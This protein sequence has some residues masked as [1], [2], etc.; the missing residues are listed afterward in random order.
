[1]LL[2]HSVDYSHKVIEYHIQTGRHTIYTMP[3]APSTLAY[4][5]EQALKKSTTTSQFVVGLV[6]G[7]LHNSVKQ[8]KASHQEPV[9]AIAW[10]ERLYSASTSGEVITW[11]ADLEEIERYSSIYDTD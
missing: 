4:P 11:S 10:G 7:H 6:N 9:S 2:C 5:Q 1:M 8:S 3:E